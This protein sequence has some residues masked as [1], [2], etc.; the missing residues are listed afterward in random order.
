MADNKKI[1]VVF[2]QA[3]GT[4]NTI[5]IVFDAAGTVTMTV[6]DCTAE[7]PSISGSLTTDKWTLSVG[8]ADGV[9]KFLY[10]ATEI[11]ASAVQSGACENR[12]KSKTF[13][14]VKIMTTDDA[15]LAYSLGERDI[16]KNW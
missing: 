9:V 2:Q 10:G 1:N 3:D 7:T 8:A 15:T 5:D 16:S 12:W 13:K 4:D 14:G 11:I 6:Q